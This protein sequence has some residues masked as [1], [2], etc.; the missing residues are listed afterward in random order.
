LLQNV[1]MHAAP[2]STRLPINLAS[3]ATLLSLVALVFGALHPPGPVS[4]SA[5][6]EIVA[7][8]RVAL[9]AITAATFLILPGLVLRARLRRCAGL[10]I[11]FIPL[12]GI[13]ILTAIG[14]VVW[15]TAKHVDSSL[16][17]RVL[18]GALLVLLL[19]VVWK[20]PPQLDVDEAPVL[21]V[22]GICFLIALGRSLWSRGPAGELYA[23]TISRTLE[24]GDRSDSRISYHVA[25]VVAHGWSPYGAQASALFAPY[26]FSD[27]GPV[28]GVLSTPI[29]LF[30]GT[31]PTA[32]I[33]DEF[34]SPFDPQGFMVY[35]IVMMMLAVCALLAVHTVTKRVASGAVAWLAVLVVAGTPFF[36]H[37]VYFTWP[38]WAAAADCLLAAYLIMERRTFLAGLMIGLGF[39]MHPIAL[40]SVPALVLLALIRD[41]RPRSVASVGRRVLSVAWIAVGLGLIVIAWRIANGRHYSQG[42]FADYLVQANGIAHPSIGQW[43]HVRAVSVANTFVPLIL[44]V[45]EGNNH[46]INSVTGPSNFVIHFFFQYW[47]G[48]PFGVSIVFYPVLLVGLVKMFRNRPWA[49]TC[50]VVIP[51]VSFAIYWGRYDTGL[52]REGLHA[53][54]LTVL[55]MWAMSYQQRFE[56]GMPLG[57]PLRVVLVIRT[58]EV[59]IMMTVPSLDA[60]HS[61]VSHQF[62][63]SDCVALITMIAATSGLAWVTWRGTAAPRARWPAI[64]TADPESSVRFTTLTE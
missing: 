42:K 52:L 22:A 23:G 12:P 54:V 64:T 55:I 57:R 44:P 45:F 40:F 1:G 46:S 20:S 49:V 47:T 32:G 58:L 63:L 26:N 60:H 30:S 50:L 61:A 4:S 53:W 11:G 29:M 3:A 24:V 14:C 2:E 62:W 15:A 35:R 37:D 8:V 38:K 56:D 43:L 16:T 21:I 33:P 13:A 25:S 10:P 18:L 34:W 5:L 9:T 39:L 6:P 19:A 59:L 36:I 41:A 48:L 27:R 7:L 17:S 31:T 28:P 51:F